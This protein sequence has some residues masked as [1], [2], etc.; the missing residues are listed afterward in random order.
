[1]TAANHQCLM[2]RSSRALPHYT[3][4]VHK[5]ENTFTE[6]GADWSARGAFP[7]GNHSKWL[8]STLDESRFSREYCITC[9]A[10]TANF[11]RPHIFIPL[12][13]GAFR[14]TFAAIAKL[15]PNA[16]VYETFACDLGA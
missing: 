6:M 10:G 8:C 5:G 14:Q 15:M 9:S 11:G 4:D 13:S 2:R 1:M 12:V 7:L 16:E 3:P